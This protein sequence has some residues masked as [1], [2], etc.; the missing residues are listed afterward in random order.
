MG[1]WVDGWVDEE[2]LIGGW[3]GGWVWYL[4][5]G[6]EDFIGE[7]EEEGVVGGEEGGDGGG[8]GGGGGEEEFED[9]GR[10][11]EVGG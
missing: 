4:G 9:E 7:G 3:E 2:V 10:G 6:M 11:G 1:R 5:E 8:G